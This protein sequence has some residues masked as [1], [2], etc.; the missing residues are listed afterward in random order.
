MIR[1]ASNGMLYKIQRG[2]NLGLAFS[3]P[4]YRI[5]FKRGEDLVLGGE[6]FKDGQSWAWTPNLG[7]KYASDCDRR[8]DAI[9]ELSKHVA[10]KWRDTP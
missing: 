2:P 8:M 10:G 6:V 7:H 3:M 9:N 4:S 5:F 1:T